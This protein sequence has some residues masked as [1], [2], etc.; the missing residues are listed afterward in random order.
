VEGR[1]ATDEDGMAAR[2]RQRSRGRERGSAPGGWEASGRGTHES[3]GCRRGGEPEV[4]G[5][6]AGV[7]ETGGR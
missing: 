2:G 3:G 5:V 7:G 6:R 1:T 4:G